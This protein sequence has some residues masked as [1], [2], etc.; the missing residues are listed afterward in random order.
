M[1]EGKR[2]RVGQLWN[3]FRRANPDRSRDGKM[4]VR[5]MGHVAEEQETPASERRFIKKWQHHYFGQAPDQISNRSLE[6]GKRVFRQA[7]CARCHSIA[8]EGAK[9][10]PDLTEVTKRFQCSKLLQQIVN[11]S[12]EI[13][14][15][16]KT[17]MIVVNN[18]RLV[19]GLVI[20][21]TDDQIRILPNLLKPDKVETITKSDIEH[22]R[23]ADLSSMPVGLLDTFTVEEI[24]DLLAFLQS[25]HKKTE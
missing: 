9:Y 3:Q 4:F 24:F 17:Q 20:E 21:E 12:T 2:G 23:I 5:I 14:K 15:E 22:R 11:P 18:G 1:P 19:T 7:A 13:H 6:N 10:G 8:G 16:F 25:D